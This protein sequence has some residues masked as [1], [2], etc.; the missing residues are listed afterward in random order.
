MIPR[1]AASA[2]LD[3]A[4]GFPVVAVTGPRQSGK[5]TLVQAVFSHKT[6]VSLEEP[7]KLELVSS[8]PRGFL[9]SFPDGAVIDEAQ[10]FPALFSYLQTL[11]DREK[12]PG[13]FILTGSQHFGLLSGI[14]QSLAGRAGLL[15]LLPFSV[16]E[17]QAAKVPIPGLPALLFQG[18]YPALYDRQVAPAAW[19]GNYVMTYLERDV[20]N[21]LNVRNL[22]TFQKF[23]RMC[24]ARVGQLLNLSS[25][26]ADCGITHNTA[27]SWLS[28]LEASYIV[29]LMRPHFRN[30]GKRL[31]KSP[32]LYFYDPGLAAWLLNIQNHDHL[33]IH[34]QRGG[35]FECLMIS[36]LLKDRFHRGLSSNLYYWRNNLGDE[37]D[38]LLDQGT[39]L[40][41]I[42][43]KSGETLNPD[44]FKG[45]HKWRKISGDTEGPAFL[46]YGGKDKFTQQGIQA[47]PWIRVSQEIQNH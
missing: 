26:A 30:F 9:E 25:M 36:E 44:F 34:P 23:L 27:Q 10:R 38:V 41:P 12:K 47:V 42:E 37:I 16:A 1:L 21:I 24:A 33:A 6:Y 18:L 43:L 2:L 35:L 5:T 13:F 39:N 31:V 17:L 7:D 20:R 22:S 45:L 4:K 29:F 15:E 11:A 19:H 14:R 46:V 28:V 40:V 3:L 8:D 32:K